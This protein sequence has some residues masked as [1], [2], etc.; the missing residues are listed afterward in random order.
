[1]QKRR[2]EKSKRKRLHLV[3]APG[4]PVISVI[5]NARRYPIVDC[6]VNSGWEESQLAD[7]VIARQQPNDLITFGVYLVELGCLGLKNAFCN[8]N[9]TRSDY[10][11]FRKD[12]AERVEG[13]VNLD[14][15]FAHQLIYGAID[16]AAAI[17]FKPHKDFDLARYVLDEKS[18]IPANPDLE[19]GMDGKP[20]YQSGPNDNVS[21]IMNHLEK[22]LGMGNFNYTV[23]MPVG[24]E[25][26]DEDVYDDGLMEDD[27]PLPGPVDDD[28]GRTD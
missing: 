4:N 9:L 2:K 26:F 10:S 24:A 18:S 20:F 8:G 22:K 17:G 6:F 15:V 27:M 3:L 13:V 7:I 23:H 21:R 28:L 5:R 1:M 14:P 16:Y 19:F 11:E 12:S 25:S